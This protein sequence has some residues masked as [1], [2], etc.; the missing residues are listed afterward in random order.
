MSPSPTYLPI[1]DSSHGKRARRVGITTCGFTAGN[2]AGVSSRASFPHLTGLLLLKLY[3]R[4]SFSCFSTPA[5]SR[6]WAVSLS[7]L[8]VFQTHDLRGHWTG[9]GWRKSR[10]RH[11]R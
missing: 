8:A 2:F 9:V 3:G 7:R 10:L 1:K 5:L 11:S 6:L 4:I